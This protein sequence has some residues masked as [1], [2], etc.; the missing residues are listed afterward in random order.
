MNHLS[1]QLSPSHS[2]PGGLLPS[3]ILR[4]ASSVRGAVLGWGVA[5]AMAGGTVML[6]QTVTRMYSLTTRDK[7]AYLVP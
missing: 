2:T 7:L 1:P 4:R 6:Q 5:S 3:S